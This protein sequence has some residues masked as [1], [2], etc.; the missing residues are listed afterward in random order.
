MGGVTLCP[1]CNVSVLSPQNSCL[2]FLL[3]VQMSYPCIPKFVSDHINKQKKLGSGGRQGMREAGRNGYLSA[4]SPCS[5]SFCKGSSQDGV[6]PLV[7]NTH[8]GFPSARLN[9]GCGHRNRES[10]WNCWKKTLINLMRFGTLQGNSSWNQ[11]WTWVRNIPEYT[12]TN[13]FQGEYV[14]RHTNG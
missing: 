1:H 2:I 3:L 9:W 12:T 13:L 6:W 5:V 8:P 7:P 11:I 10:R 4:L 14:L